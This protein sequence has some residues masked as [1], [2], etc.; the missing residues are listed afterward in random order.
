MAFS[1]LSPRDRYM[2]YIDR[3]YYTVLDISESPLYGTDD[4]IMRLNNV[5]ALYETFQIYSQ[6]NRP[7]VSR[8]IEVID[9]RIEELHGGIA[10]SE[11]KSSYSPTNTGT[12]ST[13]ATEHVSVRTLMR[14]R[15]P[16]IGHKP[17]TPSPLISGEITP[18]TPIDSD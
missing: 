15:N 16:L 6:E 14:V 18:L 9:R 12:E 3:T 10:E 1:P 2:A 8:K 11:S 5:R 13:R 7:T 17:L 4:K